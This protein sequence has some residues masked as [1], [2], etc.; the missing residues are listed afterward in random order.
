VAFAHHRPVTN[1]IE[2]AI[3]AD[4]ESGSFL[5]AKE[6]TGVLVISFVKS[7]EPD[8]VL[9]F[10]QLSGLPE[11]WLGCGPKKTS[12]RN[13]N[14]YQ[15][16]TPNYQ[17]TALRNHRA[18]GC[19]PKFKFGQ[20]GLVDQW[21]INAKVL[22]VAFDGKA[23]AKFLIRF[24]LRSRSSGRTR[25]FADSDSRSQNESVVACLPSKDTRKSVSGVRIKCQIRGFVGWKEGRPKRLSFV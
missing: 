14:S 4:F 10:G 2:E 22:A 1:R 8:K 19:L 24:L 23:D 17:R 12:E 21:C 9:E 20:S 13:R 7:S 11:G 25:D 3:V 6:S 5:A 16:K 15:R 18:H